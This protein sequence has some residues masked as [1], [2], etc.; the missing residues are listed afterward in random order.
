[1]YF[2][3]VFVLVG[4]LTANAASACKLQGEK[5]GIPNLSHCPKAVS[6]FTARAVMCQHFA[7][8]ING[9]N[10]PRDKQVNAQLTKLKC[11]TLKAN[12]ARMMKKYAGNASIAK[13]IQKTIDDYAIELY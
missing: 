10:S 3:F 1:M 11:T 13:V 7:G 6:K 8:E 9:D 2:R 4:L 12:H 5:N